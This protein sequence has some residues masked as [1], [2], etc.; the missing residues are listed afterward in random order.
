M[1]DKAVYHSHRRPELVAVLPE[2]PNNRVLDLGCGTGAMSSL[3]REEHKASEVWGVE[4]FPDAA[5]R[6][7]DCAALN[8]V[9]S[10]DLEEVIDQIPAEHFTHVI[11][12]DIL[13]H[14]V[15]PW[16][17]CEKLRTKLVPGGTFICS[18]PNIRNIS[19]LLALTFKGRFEYKESGVMDRTHLRF[20]ARKDVHDLFSGA[21]FVDIS[22]NPVRPKTRLSWHIGRAVLGDLVIKGFLVTAR[23]P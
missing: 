22:I 10:G 5:Q 14:L 17:V 4:K 20:F 9:L 7:R 16:V 23:K 12:G 1:S 8:K 21:G 13:E 11:A 3:I 15:D 2:D 19:F 18:I 6:A